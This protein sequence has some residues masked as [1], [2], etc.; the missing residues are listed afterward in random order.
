MFQRG[1]YFIVDVIPGTMAVI[2]LNTIYFYDSNKGERVSCSLRRFGTFGAGFRF[3]GPGIAV[4]RVAG[5]LPALPYRLKECAG[6]GPIHRH[7]LI[8]SLTKCPFP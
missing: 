6:P 7:H 5:I 8:S 1:G 2:S 4:R 3:Q